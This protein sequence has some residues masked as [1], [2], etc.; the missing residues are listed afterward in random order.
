VKAQLE[1]TGG[2]EM[3]FD[4]GDCRVQVDQADLDQIPELRRRRRDQ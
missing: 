1:G 4:F 3:V 2:D